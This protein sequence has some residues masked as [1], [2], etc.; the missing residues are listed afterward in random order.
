M[1]GGVGSRV[2]VFVDPR[3][4][5]LL[6]VQPGIRLGLAQAGEEVSAVHRHSP[7]GSNYSDNYDSRE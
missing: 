7:Y 6:L 4:A 1:P 2:W 3:Y 5:Q